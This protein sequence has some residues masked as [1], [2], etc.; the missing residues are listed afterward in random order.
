[1]PE[2]NTLAYFVLSISDREKSF[3]ATMPETLYH[4]NDWRWKFVTSFVAS[5]MR[6][7]Q[8]IYIVTIYDLLLQVSFVVIIEILQE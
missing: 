5:K 3:V 4:F 1:L 7:K 8:M 6:Q 2:T